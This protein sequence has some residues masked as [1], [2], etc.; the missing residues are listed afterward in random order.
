LTW[1]W[2]EDQKFP[3]VVELARQ[4][5]GILISQIEIERIFSIVGIFIAL[6]DVDFKLTIWT[7]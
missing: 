5:L 7:S 3:I 1:W 6:R 4:I 2:I